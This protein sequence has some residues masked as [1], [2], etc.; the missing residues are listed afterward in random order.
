MSVGQALLWG[1]QRLRDYNTWKS[2][3]EKGSSCTESI[4]QS[5]AALIIT[6]GV[7]GAENE[8]GNGLLGRENLEPVAP[9]LGVLKQ[10]RVWGQLRLHHETL[11]QNI[12]AIPPKEN[13]MNI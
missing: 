7:P 3:Q 6:I 12:P 11:S 8:Q 9:T 10:V 4:P 1:K 13:K 2:Y 5:L